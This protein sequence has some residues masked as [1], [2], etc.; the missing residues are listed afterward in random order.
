VL[1]PSFVFP[2][3]SP[4]PSCSPYCPFLPVVIFFFPSPPPLLPLPSPHQTPPS[5]IFCRVLSFLVLVFF[6]LFSLFFFFVVVVL[7]SYSFF[8]FSSLFFSPSP[9]P[10]VVFTA[11]R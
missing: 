1:S 3:R 9:S 2:L 8:L 7:S 11:H 6:V 5:P 10:F 4:S